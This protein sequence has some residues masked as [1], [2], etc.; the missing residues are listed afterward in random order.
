VS[1]DVSEETVV[2][3]FNVQKEAE[4][5]S[6]VK[7]VTRSTDTKRGVIVIVR[8]IYSSTVQYQFFLSYE[9]GN[10]FGPENKH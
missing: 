8:S 5:E 1:R 4:Q 9:V 6:S 7:E 2:S 10:G 3:N